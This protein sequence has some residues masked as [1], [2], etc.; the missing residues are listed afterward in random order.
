MPLASDTIYLVKCLFVKKSGTTAAALLFWLR[1]TK[2]HTH[3]CGCWMLDVI[4]RNN[5]V[6]MMTR[7]WESSGL[8][9][10]MT[11]HFNQCRSHDIPSKPFTMTF[12]SSNRS[13]LALK[14]APLKLA[15]S[16]GLGSHPSSGPVTD[17]ERTKGSSC[18]DGR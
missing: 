1:L 9:P 17:P 12:A 16:R 2:T 4:Q 3:T 11:F 6:H 18:A 10:F 7:L 14:P 15:L 13:S 8:F 5:R